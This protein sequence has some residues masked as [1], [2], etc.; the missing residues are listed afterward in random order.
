MR[1]GAMQLLSKALRLSEHG[2]ARIAE[3]LLATLSPEISNLGDDALKAE[4]HRRLAEYQ[5]DSRSAVEWSKLRGE[6]V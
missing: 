1:S 5:R 2:R 4:L 3:E 6:S